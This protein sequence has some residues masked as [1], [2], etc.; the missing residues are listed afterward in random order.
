MRE[1]KI[2]EK[3]SSPPLSLYKKRERKRKTKKIGGEFFAAPP[4]LSIHAFAEVTRERRRRREKTETKQRG[5]EK[6]KEEQLLKRSRSSFFFLPDLTF[7]LEN[8]RNAI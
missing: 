6:K 8:E 5:G 7:S 3:I 4:Q 2:F 1:K